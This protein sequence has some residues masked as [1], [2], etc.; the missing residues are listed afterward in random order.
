VDNFTDLNKRVHENV[1]LWCH[2]TSLGVDVK[3]LKHLGD[4]FNSKK[5]GFD[6]DAKLQLLICDASGPQE[7]LEL[8]D[9]SLQDCAKSPIALVDDRFSICRWDG[10]MVLLEYRSY[11]PGMIGPVPINDRKREVMES[12]A[13]LLHQPKE[14]A[15]RTP[16][17]MGWYVEYLNNRVA[18]VFRLPEN[19]G[20]VP[21]TLLQTLNSQ[22]KPPLGD[23]FY[24]AHSLAKSMSQMQLVKWVG[25]P[26]ASS[27][28]LLTF[29]QGA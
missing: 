17:C 23:R 18:F 20:S 9:K 27:S 12:L 29:P 24:L 11:A 2:A 22:I 3:H 26:E 7:S 5:L 21:F 14:T 13:R 10:K 19:F 15:F 1:Q 6:I 28:S 25:R 16:A 4:D 8:H